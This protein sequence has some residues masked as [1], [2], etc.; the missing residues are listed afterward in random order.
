MLRWQD[1]VP[2]GRINASVAL[3]GNALFLYGGMMEVGDQEV[4]L[5]DLYLMDIAKL[6][7]WHCLIE[8]G[9]G[10]GGGRGE[11]GRGGG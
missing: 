4:T 2:C 11:R 10:G 1:S 9:G 7:R 3:S 6:D 5:D 8:V